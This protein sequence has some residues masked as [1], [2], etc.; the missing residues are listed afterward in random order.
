MMQ[1]MTDAELVALI[2]ENLKL[3]IAYNFKGNFAKVAYEANCV[4]FEEATRRGIVDY[5]GQRK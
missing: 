4:L 5:S 1:A 3:Q 2:K